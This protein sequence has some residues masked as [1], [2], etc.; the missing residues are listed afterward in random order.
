MKIT[1][2]SE[3][4][5]WDLV[6]NFR[7]RVSRASG[8]TLR[9]FTKVMKGTYRNFGGALFGAPPIELVCWLTPQEFTMAV[10]KGEIKP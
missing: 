7:T 9:P 8:D 5:N 1:E 4:N 3:L 6:W 2:Y 10:I